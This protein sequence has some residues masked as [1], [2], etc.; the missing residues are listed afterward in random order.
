MI[1]PDFFLN[2]ETDP[3]TDPE[4]RKVAPWQV[5]EFEDKEGL[6]GLCSEDDSWNSMSRSYCK[7]TG[8]LASNIL[9][10]K[11]EVKDLRTLRSCEKFPNHMIQHDTT[12]L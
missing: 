6:S 11:F 4:T 2:E 5:M 10:V 8:V 7:E 1:I 3:S 12:R 9:P